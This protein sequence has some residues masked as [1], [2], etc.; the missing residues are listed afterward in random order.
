MKIRDPAFVAQLGLPSTGRIWTDLDRAELYEHAIRNREAMTVTSGSLLALTGRHTG[1]SPRDRFFVARRESA[2]QLWR[3][4][5]NALLSQGQFESIKERV[6]TFCA[7][8]D[9]YAQNLAAGVPPHRIGVRVITELAW[10]SLFARNLLSPWPQAKLG[11]T[12]GVTVLVMP[13]VAADPIRDGT[14]SETFVLIDIDQRLILIGGTRY[15]G[16]IKKAVF[17]LLNYLMPATGVLPMHC[18]A[19]QGEDGKVALFFGLSG[20]GKTTLSAAP[21]RALIGDDEHGWSDDGIFNF[22]GGCYAKTVGISAQTQPEIFTASNRFGTV[23]EN[24]AIDPQTGEPDFVDQHLTENARAAYPLEFLP[25]TIASRSG[26]HPSQILFLSADTFGVLPPVARLSSAQ[27]E[28]FFLAGYTAKI[29][30]TELGVNQPEAT[31]SPCF[32]APFLPLPPRLYAAMLQERVLR[33]DAEVWMLNTGWIGGGPGIGN[34]IP[35]VQTRAIVDAILNGK[36]RD[37]PTHPDPVFELA[38]PVAVPNIAAE[39]L[40]QRAAWKDRAPEFDRQAAPHRAMFDD[41]HARLDRG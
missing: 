1:R 41:H 40:N 15:A 30:A 36:L 37:V 34:R 24:V 14:N 38:V 11:Q 8:H 31:F 22:E 13:S 3:H 19:N 23:L 39:T 5:G 4:P 9:L 33:H 16:E 35:L 6:L 17:T 18:A 32:A 12:G 21:G 7:D 2:Q 29:S 10:H 28:Y 20:T 27:I 25:S 26:G